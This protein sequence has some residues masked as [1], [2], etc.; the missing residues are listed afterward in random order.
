M[1]L[2]TMDFLAFCLN[3]DILENRGRARIFWNEREGKDGERKRGKWVLAI[4]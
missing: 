4:L 1:M 3:S 2:R